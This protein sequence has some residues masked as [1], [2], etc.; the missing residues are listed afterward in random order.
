MSQPADKK[1]SVDHNRIARVIF[2]AAESMGISDR[3]RIE[4]LTTE[5]IER[6]AQVPPVPTLPGMEDLVAESGRRQ[7]R[8]PSDD[9]IEA[10]VREILDAEKRPRRELEK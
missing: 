9:E 5:V 2:A 1:G 7:K 4:Q 8:L 10:M 3:K 6:V